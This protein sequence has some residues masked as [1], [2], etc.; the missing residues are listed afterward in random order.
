[1]KIKNIE[2]FKQ[3]YTN[4]GFEK[5]GNNYVKYLKGAKQNWRIEIDFAGEC[6]AIFNHKNEKDKPKF[7]TQET[8]TNTLL[9]VVRDFGY[10]VE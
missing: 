3:E 9:D 7:P 10:E 1:M 2:R 8:I 4:Y 6:S 5:I